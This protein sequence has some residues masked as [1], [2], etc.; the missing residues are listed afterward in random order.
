MPDNKREHRVK[1]PKKTSIT[2][3]SSKEALYDYYS[4]E[5]DRQSERGTMRGKKYDRAGFDLIFNTALTSNPKD[6]AERAIKKITDQQTTQIRYRSARELLS[7]LKKREDYKERFKD[8]E[9]TVEKIRRLEKDDPRVKPVWDVLKNKYR[10]LVKENNYDSEAAGR[11]YR[12]TYF[13]S[14]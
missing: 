8:L 7:N 9:L 12:Q 10:D 14:P 2:R 3:Y 4:K 1:N 5:Y 6:S 13:G 11:I